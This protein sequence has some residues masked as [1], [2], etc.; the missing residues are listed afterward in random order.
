MLNEE[1][2]KIMHRILHEL[3]SFS[4]VY[5]ATIKNINYF[6]YFGYQL[7]WPDKFEIIKVYMKYQKRENRNRIFFD[8][9]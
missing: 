3:S 9:M 2:I 8:F 6:G 4:R 1:K 7:F 5:F